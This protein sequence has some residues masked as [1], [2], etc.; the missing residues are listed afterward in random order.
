M[1]EEDVEIIEAMIGAIERASEQIGGR[2]R[3]GLLVW[4][5]DGEEFH[6]EDLAISPDEAL[7]VLRTSLLDGAAINGLRT[8]AR[9]IR[10]CED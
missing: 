5:R 2:S 7:S 4:H 3:I 1:T 8:L 9:A 6:R 10:G